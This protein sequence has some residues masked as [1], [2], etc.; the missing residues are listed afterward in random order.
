MYDNLTFLFT[1]NTLANTDDS[2]NNLYNISK[3]CQLNFNMRILPFF[4]W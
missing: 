2:D 4:L 1:W 3:K